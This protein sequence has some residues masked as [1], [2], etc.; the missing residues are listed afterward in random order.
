MVMIHMKLMSCGLIEKCETVKTGSARKARQSLISPSASSPTKSLLLHLNSH[1]LKF[2]DNVFIFKKSVYSIKKGDYIQIK[3]NSD[4][5]SE[6]I[7]K[8][9]QS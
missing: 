4:F 2:I 8:D 9:E 1:L 3:L 5:S 6:K 7:L